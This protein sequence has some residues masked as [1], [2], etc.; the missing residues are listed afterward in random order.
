MG[1]VV[2]VVVDL[3]VGQTDLGDVRF[4]LLG[5]LRL[6]R[7][8]SFRDRNLLLFFGPLAFA[9][10]DLGLVFR[11]LPFGY[12]DRRLVFGSFSLLDRY[13]TLLFGLRALLVGFDLFLFSNPSS[14]GRRC[15]FAFLRPSE[16]QQLYCARFE[17]KRTQSRSS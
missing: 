2:G 12:R 10:G 11:T 9:D 17:R 15:P 5:L 4:V 6:L 1:I 14:A 3:G 16:P 13:A 8:L 7:L